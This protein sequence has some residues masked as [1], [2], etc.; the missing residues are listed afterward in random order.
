MKLV[1]SQAEAMFVLGEHHED[2]ILDLPNEKHLFGRKQ[3]ELGCFAHLPK[4]TLIYWW[5]QTPSGTSFHLD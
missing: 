1:R 2:C 4:T 5:Y 3:V